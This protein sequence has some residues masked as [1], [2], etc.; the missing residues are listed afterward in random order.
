MPALSKSGGKP[1]QSKNSESR[2]LKKLKNR[3]PSKNSRSL[4]LNQSLLL[5]IGRKEQNRGD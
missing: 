1:P 5:H 4:L 2:R 3:C